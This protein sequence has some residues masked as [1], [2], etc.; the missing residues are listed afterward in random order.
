VLVVIGIPVRRT[1][2]EAKGLAGTPALAALAAARAGVKVELVGKAGEDAAGAAVVLALGQQGVGHAALLRDSGH[3]TP[4]VA[5][6]PRDDPPSVADES[7]QD[8][9]DGTHSPDR[10]GWPALE[11]EDVQLALRYLPDIRAIVVA[12]PVPDA[13][14]DVVKDAASYLAAP[15]V[16]VADPA[17][18]PEADVVLAAPPSDPDGAFAEVLGQ[19]G[20]ALD[21]GVSAEDAFREVSSRLGLAPARS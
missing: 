17:T 12:E 11:P 3:D 2:S 10:S 8:E 4:V 14:L 7:A 18:S 20:A 5:D 13:V 1:G 9:P 16:V 6:P 21:R 15:V 19:V